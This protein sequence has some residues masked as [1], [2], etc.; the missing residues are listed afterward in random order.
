MPVILLRWPK[1]RMQWQLTSKSPLHSAGQTQRLCPHRRWCVQPEGEQG[2]IRTFEKETRTWKKK[3]CLN[4]NLSTG[5]PGHQAN[6]AED[7]VRGPTQ[8]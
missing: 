5:I 8:S 7:S 4:Q 6:S 1:V 2:Y 3:N